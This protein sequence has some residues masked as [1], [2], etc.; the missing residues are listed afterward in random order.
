[1]AKR[2]KKTPY[3]HLPR[4]KQRDSFIRLRQKIRNKSSIYG[5]Q[6]TSRHILDEPGRPALYNQWADVYFLGS[7]GLTIWNA[8]IV[9]AVREFW[10]TAEDMAHTKAWEMLTPEEQS[11]E[12]EMKFEPVWIKG[13]PMYQ[14]LEK[15]DIVYEKLGGLTYRDYQKKLTEE[16]IQNEPP[17]VFESFATDRSYRYGVGLNMV[18]HVSEINRI[19]IEEAIRRFREVGETDWRAAE[20]VPRTELPF[21]SADTAYK[22][23]QPTPDYGTVPQ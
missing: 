12:A 17:E 22:K 8:A 4:R 2:K 18:I 15:T 6:F 3:C 9:T 16:I 19:T 10:D 20:P 13:K 14:L 5:G 23:I 11:A 1:M 7:D 21:E